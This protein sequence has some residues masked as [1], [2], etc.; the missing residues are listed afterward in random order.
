MRARDIVCA[1][2]ADA[3]GQRPLKLTFL[4]VAI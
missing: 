2:R 3:A 1:Q 4:T